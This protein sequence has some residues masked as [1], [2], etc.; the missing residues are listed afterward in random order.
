MKNHTTIIVAAVLALLLGSGIFIRS[1][2]HRNAFDHTVH[3]ALKTSEGYDQRFIDMV[4]RLEDVLAHRASFGYTGGKDPMTGKV[5]T[6]VVQQ[7]APVVKH[8]D[9]PAKPSVQAVPEKPDPFKLTAIIYDD[10]ENKYTA[11]IMVEERSFSIGQGETVAGRKIQSITNDR[12]IMEDDMNIYLYDT[13]GRR[14]IR[15]KVDQST[16]PIPGTS[17]ATSSQG[18]SAQALAPGASTSTAKAQ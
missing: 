3:E 2:M 5:R 16:K 8:A 12:I 13:S 7:H 14:S 17:E 18:M 6:V 11:I 15:S 9:I 1:R 10:I 4:N